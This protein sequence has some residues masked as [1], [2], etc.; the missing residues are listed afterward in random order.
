MK[1]SDRFDQMEA[2]ARVVVKPGVCVCVSGVVRSFVRAIERGEERKLLLLYCW[3]YASCALACLAWLRLSDPSP[4]VRGAEVFSPLP[5]I[6]IVARAALRKHATDF[7]P[8][9]TRREV[10]LHIIG[11]YNL[12][13]IFTAGRSVTFLSPLSRTPSKERSAVW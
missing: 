2:A 11:L 13:Y 1:L 12:V 5:Y 9:F 3:T 8:L 4:L 10:N 6:F 7:P